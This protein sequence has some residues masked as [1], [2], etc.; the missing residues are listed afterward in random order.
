MAADQNRPEG[1][2][3]AGG[4]GARDDR[5]L[6]RGGEPTANEERPF[7]QRPQGVL[8]VVGGFVGIVG[9]IL[10]LVF[11]LLPD[12]QPEPTPEPEPGVEL[13]DFDLDKE[14]LIQADMVSG[15]GEPQTTADWRSSL[16]TVIL[17]NNGDNPALVSQAE[18]RFSKIAE[19]GCPYGAG[20]LDVKARYDI[21]VPFEARAPMKQ[22]RK[23]KYTVPPHEQER[24]AFTVGP[25]RAYEG[26]LPQVYVFTIILRLTDGSHIEI[27]KM[28][29]MDPFGQE[30][31]LEA[32]EQAMT[33][34]HFMA[35]E[36]C[37]REQESKAR[38]L[39]RGTKK[40]S[41]ELRNFSTQLTRITSRNS[42]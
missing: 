4:A 40:V 22:V 12:L 35:T 20:G 11:L 38:N 34:G 6:P 42:T 9:G 39:V 15:G 36:A 17:G 24:V 5:Q 3:S 25:E 33:S 37:V 1:A 26:N 32:A 27:P 2:G 8:A 41:P 18:F 30:P 16:V 28:T 23:M 19:I 29:Y 7:L 10:G 31:A 14:A 13:V 21:K